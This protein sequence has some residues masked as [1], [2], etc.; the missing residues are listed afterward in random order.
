M[1]SYVGQINSGGSNLP[2]ASTLY[3]TC[4]TAANTAAKVVTCANFDKLLTGV[5]IHVKFTNSNTVA[6][7][8]LNVNSTGAK[9]IY[10]YGTTT[11]GTAASSS[12]NAGAVVSFTYDGSAWQMNDWVNTDANDDTK[13]KQTAIN[14]NYDFPVV[15]KKSAN[16]TTQT[17]EVNTTN[18]TSGS[19]VSINPSTGNLNVV[20]INSVAVGSSPK[21]TDTT[22]ESKSATS[23]GTDVSLVT[24]GEK[25]TWNNKS[26][27]TIGTTATTAAAGNH[28]HGLSIATDSGTNQLTMAANTKYKLTAGGSTYIFT[29]PPDNNNNTWRNVQVNGT[30]ILGTGTGTGAL[31]LKAGSNV[32]VTNSSGTVTIAA[33]DTTYSDATTSAHGLMTAADKTKLNGIATGAEVNQNAFANVTVGST[34]IAADAKQDTLT[35]VAGSNVTLTPDATNDKVT[36]A[37][38]D[39]TYS[40][41]T[42]A[43]GGTD[44]SL[45]TTGEKYTWNNKSNL[46][47]GTTATTAAAGNHTHG[48]SIATDSG[49]NQLTMAA[50]TKYKL[51]AGGS[52]YIFTT[53]PD[54]VFEVIWGTTTFADAKAAHDAGK[55]LILVAS[56]ECTCQYYVTNSAIHFYSVSTNSMEIIIKHYSLDSS[57]QRRTEVLEHYSGRVFS[58]DDSDSLVWGANYYSFDTA[59]T[60]VVF[61]DDIWDS[62]LEQC[63]NIIFL[64][65]STNAT[66]TA[67]R[68]YK[69]TDGLVTTA[70]YGQLVYTNL[71]PGSIYECNFKVLNNTTIG[72]IMKEWP[73]A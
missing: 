65:A 1:A 20:K 64:A 16:V 34:T 69:I 66:F 5:T 30:E 43:S 67:P 8:T 42:A 63:I 29:T 54:E 10:R 68:F 52:T 45:V 56:G 73:T 31:N 4:E 58:Y 41:K 32:S 47:I 53:P 22:Y 44:V 23:G 33:T 48:L 50:N 51:T 71:T 21:F 62:S 6:N 35:L 13:V 28:T 57:N 26:N 55:P 40:S 19:A 38:T 25:Y 36:I 61:L 37:A 59:V 2:V 46:A 49:T 9:S 3:G 12:W 7:P 14:S 39:T 11:P 15:L 17:D 60:P 70:V 72:L 18:L 24:T 27:L